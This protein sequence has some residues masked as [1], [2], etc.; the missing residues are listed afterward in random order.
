MNWPDLR[1]ILCLCSVIAVTMF[2]SM[3]LGERAIYWLLGIHTLMN[4]LWVTFY[5][6][7]IGE[8]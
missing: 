1:I 4:A 7:A 5:L 8:I 3:L 2:L 6:V